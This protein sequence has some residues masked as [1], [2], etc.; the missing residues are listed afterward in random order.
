MKKEIVR[1]AGKPVL[2]KD[3]GLN[4]LVRENGTQE[5]MICKPDGEHGGREV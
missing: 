3:K 2:R 1:N 4:Y 5:R